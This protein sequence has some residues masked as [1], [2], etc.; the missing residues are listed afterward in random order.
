MP[1]KISSKPWIWQKQSILNKAGQFYKKC[2]WN[3]LKQA[4]NECK[5]QHL[6]DKNLNFFQKIW[7]QVE[8]WIL[9]SLINIPQLMD[10]GGDW[11]QSFSC[12]FGNKP[13]NAISRPTSI[14]THTPLMLLGTTS[15]AADEPWILLTGTMW[16]WAL[17]LTKLSDEYSKLQSWWSSWRTAKKI[18]ILPTQFLVCLYQLNIKPLQWWSGDIL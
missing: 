6:D 17:I 14:Q 12:T 18:G 16:L 2:S 10:P 11:F 9:A 1:V 8:T 4:E 7:I 3:D 15:C 5:W 13:R